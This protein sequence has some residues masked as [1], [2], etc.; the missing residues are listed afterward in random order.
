MKDNNGSK[1]CRLIHRRARYEI[2]PPAGHGEQEAPPF[3]TVIKRN[4]DAG[5]FL[6]VSGIDGM[7]KP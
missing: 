3:N 2:D 4:E 1:L 7:G 6:N 5:T